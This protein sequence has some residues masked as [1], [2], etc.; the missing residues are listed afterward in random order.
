MACKRT[1]LPH[2]PLTDLR[3]YGRYSKWMKEQQEWLKTWAS[4]SIPIHH[5]QLSH[6]I[7]RYIIF[8]LLFVTVDT[9]VPGSHALLDLGVTSSSPP[10]V[11]REPPEHKALLHGIISQHPHTAH[12]PSAYTT[13]TTGNVFIT[14]CFQNCHG[15]AAAA[16][17]YCCCC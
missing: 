13:S 14:G 1:V 10:P 12:R 6:H 7:R 17:K 2:L 16:G 5:S 11:K 9:A 3:F 4:T 15:L 8:A